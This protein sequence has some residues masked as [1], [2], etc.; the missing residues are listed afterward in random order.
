MRLPRGGRRMEFIC[1]VAIINAVV[2]GS[3]SLLP[4]THAVE[5]LMIYRILKLGALV[6]ANGRTTGCGKF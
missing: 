5:V 6:E 3:W 1:T 4:V 2:A